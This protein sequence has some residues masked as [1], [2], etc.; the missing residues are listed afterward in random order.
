M[1]LHPLRILGDDNYI[2]LR[3]V[4]AL[5]RP[6]AVLIHNRTFN[7]LFESRSSND[8]V[9]VRIRLYALHLQTG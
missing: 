4:M 3:E 2:E 5:F 7:R 9:R 8:D 1:H 6:M